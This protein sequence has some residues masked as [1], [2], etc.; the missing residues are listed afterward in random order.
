MGGEKNAP[1]VVVL[2]GPERI[3]KAGCGVLPSC[4]LGFIFAPMSTDPHAQLRD[5]VFDAVFR[6]PG[7]SDPLLRAA[8]AK[9]EGL[10]PDLAALVT[11]IH[12]HAF[13]VTN[14]DVA[15]PQ[16][17]Y[18]DDAM[19]EIIVSATLGASR[20]RLDAALAALEEA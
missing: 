11:K 7:E 16:R 18:G 12:D 20:A 2:G 14:E 17:V 15:A 13:K 5:A 9:N 1:I 4:A 8:A 6:G 3:G 10:P 19:F